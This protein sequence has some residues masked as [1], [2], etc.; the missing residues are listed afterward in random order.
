LVSRKVPAV[1]DFDGF[2]KVLRPGAK[3]SEYL[4]LVLYERATQGASYQELHAWVRPSMR[5]NLRATL[6]RLVHKDA[7]VHEAIGRFYLTKLGAAEVRS[8]FGILHRAI[9]GISA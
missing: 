4:L 3:V 5:T 9:S 8:G 1:E 7:L 2:L 6:N